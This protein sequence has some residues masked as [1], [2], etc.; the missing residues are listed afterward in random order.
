M[1]V[2]S[3]SI[4]YVASTHDLYIL[5]SVY[6][7]VHEIC[8]YGTVYTVLPCTIIE[9]IFYSHCPYAVVASRSMTIVVDP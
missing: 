7:V 5:Y 1:V 9:C 3:S 2:P 8:T 4:V 6:C